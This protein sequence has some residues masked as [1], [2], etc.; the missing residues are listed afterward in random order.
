MHIDPAISIECDNLLVDAQIVAAVGRDLERDLRCD[1]GELAEY[2]IDATI[3]IVM[4][5]GRQVVVA[6]ALG[7]V[8]Y[9]GIELGRVV[10]RVDQVE[11]MAVDEPNILRPFDKLAQIRSAPAG[12]G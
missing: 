11:Q 7:V 5:E 4:E 8:G 1:D 10:R 9:P 6:G 3:D 12:Q 2:I